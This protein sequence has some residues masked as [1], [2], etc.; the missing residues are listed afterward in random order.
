MT[1]HSGRPYPLGATWEQSGTN[2]AVFS[3]H[4]D[5]IDLCL[6]DDTDSKETRLALPSRTNHVWHGFLPDAAPGLRYGYRAH[7]PRHLSAGHRF[8]P[9]KLLLDPYAKAIAGPLRWHAAL[10]DHATSSADLGDA[11]DSAR[12]LPKGLVVDTA[13]DWEH[14]TPPR[15][16]WD[17]TVLY[18]CHVKGLTF[19][20]PQVPTEHRGKYLGLAAPPIL[21]HLVRLGVTSV[22]LLPVQ[23]FF[24]SR[25]LVNLGL[26]NYW[27]YNTIGYF[28]P[29]ARYAS[30]A[31]GQQV[32]EF[33]T[34][35]KT[36]HRHGLEVILDVVFNHTG[37]G[38]LN[39]P[40]LLFRGLDNRTYYRA[41]PD[42]P[43]QYWNI[44]GCGNTLDTD[45]P[46]VLQFVM[47]CLRYWVQEM[48]V[49]G[50]RFDLATALARRHHDFDPRHALLQAI[51]Q[52]PLLAP[53]KLLAEP[54]DLGPGGYQVGN[55]PGGWSEWN[56]QF[57]DHVRRF[58]RGDAGFVPQLASR[59]AGS[60]D[61]FAGEGRTPC[62]GVNFITCHD[63]FTLADL[64]R[65]EQKHN[66]ANGEHNRDGTDTNYSRNWG[67]EGPTTDPILNERRRRLVRSLLATLAFS[68]GVPMLCAG[69]ELGRTQNGN[70]NAYGQDNETSWI[71]WSRQAVDEPL[72]AFVAQL[73]AARR[74]CPELS[75]DKFFVG[76]SPDGHRDVEWLRPDG[77]P[78]RYENWGE[79]DRR[80]L[81]M[82]IR[83]REHPPRAVLA[84]FN[85]GQLPCPFVLPELPSWTCLL[86]TAEAIQAERAI[87]DPSVR[88]AE[89]SVVLL[90]G[91]RP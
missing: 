78:F 13:F 52:D 15:V 4:A 34:M 31:Q 55:F 14:D 57:R 24:D 20:H 50:F 83:N 32:R 85:A 5:A 29:E 68:R 67:V 53:V 6:F 79:S 64:V 47:D 27:G 22:E 87:T 16:P 71:D 33:K 75:R 61:L 77:R 10:D 72:C 41:T 17:R 39:G 28:A 73:L 74:T 26:V 84:L 63:G 12:H 60:S 21:E 25:F 3:E 90:V 9:R 7:G 2:F 19:R 49:D 80:E 59:L 18:E 51:A 46:R 48:H 38:D 1:L 91:H 40:T 69:D 30:T 35:V 81:G 88:V 23:Q 70:N 43:G 89:Q 44:T 82:L 45:R 56:D 54:W 66:H 62:A 86:D 65:Y 58:W 76:D 11:R 42:D 36:L 37:E 8:N